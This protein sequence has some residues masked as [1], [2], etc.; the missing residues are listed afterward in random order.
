MKGKKAYTPNEIAIF[1]AI[2][3]AVE[4]GSEGIRRSYQSALEN[5]IASG[6]MNRHDFE[7]TN[8]LR[9]GR[10]LAALNELYESIPENVR[11]ALKSSNISINNSLYTN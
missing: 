7:Q 2:H 8:C 11:D 10:A 1:F 3:R 4:E 5:A 9:F 6:M